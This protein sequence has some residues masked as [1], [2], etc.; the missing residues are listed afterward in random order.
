M[1]GDRRGRSGSRR[2]ARR[3]LRAEEAERGGAG[4]A[5][6]DRGPPPGLARGRA[7]LHLP[8]SSSL[9]HGLNPKCEGQG[10]GLGPP[11]PS[12]RAYL[13]KRGRRS[14]PACL[15]LPCQG[16]EHFAL[17]FSS[18]QQHPKPKWRGSWG[19]GGTETEH[20]VAGHRSARC[21]IFL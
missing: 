11:R 7:P 20:S 9:H 8:S 17:S 6:R 16:Q 3:R 18:L 10:R 1:E 12:G 2:P 13:E 21:P 5:Q 14:L 19:K 4:A 15:F